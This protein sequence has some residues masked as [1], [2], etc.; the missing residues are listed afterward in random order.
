MAY[1]IAEVGRQRLQRVTGVLDS[2]VQQGCHQRGGVHAEFSQDVR[3]RNGVRDVRVARA[4][5]L[6]GVPFVCHLIG[7][8]QQQQVGLREELAVNGDQRLEHRVHRAAL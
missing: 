3:H 5:Q 4:A 2:V 1:L 8:L 7:S 6:V